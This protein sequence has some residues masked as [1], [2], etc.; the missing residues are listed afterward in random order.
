MI[1]TVGNQDR[2]FCFISRV[3]RQRFRTVGI[4]IYKQQLI[5]EGHEGS[6]RNTKA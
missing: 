1:E 6:Q 2:R 5:H 3:S 4:S